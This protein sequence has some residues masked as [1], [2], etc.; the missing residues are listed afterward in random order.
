[1]DNPEHTS[2]TS[3]SLETPRIEEL[4]GATKENLELLER[5][6]HHEALEISGMR[7]QIERLSKFFGSPFYLIFTALFIIAWVC[8][9]LWG[10]RSGWR[11][12]DEPPFFLLQGLI[13]ANALLLT[14]AVLIRQYRMAQSAT[15]RSH[16]DLQ[17]NLLTEQKVS[18]LVQIVA[19][20][21]RELTAL[22]PRH[23]AEV[24]DL[25]K[26]ADANAIM[27][28]IKGKQGES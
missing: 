26:P 15:H 2:Q 13:S 22:R 14:I 21:Q 16:L 18:K 5:F 12:V 19:D 25:K 7:V 27:H 24:E 6:E 23:D 11:H 28:A 9:N 8:A 1:M 3:N 4:P 20:L 10:L 17:I